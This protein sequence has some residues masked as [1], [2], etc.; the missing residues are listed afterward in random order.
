MDDDATKERRNLDRRKMNKRPQAHTALKSR[1]DELRAADK[2]EKT[3]QKTNM[4]TF[5]WG[6]T[7]WT[8]LNDCVFGIDTTVD[9]APCKLYLIEFCLRLC[10]CHLCIPLSEHIAEQMRL[11]NLGVDPKLILWLAHNAVNKKLN[12]PL[13]RY[14]K[15]VKRYEASSFRDCDLI[16]TGFYTRLFDALSVLIHFHDMSI[17]YPI[18]SCVAQ[19]VPNRAQSTQLHAAA[20]CV[21]VAELESAF[22]TILPGMKARMQAIGQNS[23]V[24]ELNDVDVILTGTAPNVASF[25]FDNN[26]AL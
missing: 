19:I 3:N 13:V 14:D 6:P 16:F 20:R 7:L 23:T 5:I 1:L 24:T 22:K 12:K 26:I 4:D 15:I 18:L 8:L 25:V 9:T 17:V 21:S 2:S 11:G 10:P